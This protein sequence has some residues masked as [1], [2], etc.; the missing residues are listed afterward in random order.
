MNSKDSLE[1]D[2][3]HYEHLY[4]DESSTPK[5]ELIKNIKFFDPVTKMYMRADVI[6]IGKSIGLTLFDDEGHW[7]ILPILWL[8]KYIELKLLDVVGDDF[9]ILIN[10]VEL[11]ISR[12]DYYS[13]W[14]Y[15]TTSNLITN[16]RGLISTNDIEE[17]IVSDSFIFNIVSEFINDIDLEFY[18]DIDNIYQLE[19][20]LE[21]HNGDYSISG[22]DS[23][24]YEEDRIISNKV[25]YIK[26]QDNSYE[27]TLENPSYIEDYIRNRLEKLKD[28]IQGYEYKWDDNEI[29]CDSSF[30][31]LLIFKAIEISRAKEWEEE[32]GEYFNY[33][34]DDKI[35]R[36][37]RAYFNIKDIDYNDQL[38]KIK[39]LCYLMHNN[40]ECRAMGY[41]R[42]YRSLERFLL[43]I[44]EKSKRV[45]NMAEIDL[46]DRFEF[47]DYIIQLF[48]NLKYQVIPLSEVEENEEGIDIVAYIHKTCLYI[49]T[50][51]YPGKIDGNV[52]EDFSVIVNLFEESK[53]YMSFE[54]M[55]SLI[56]TNGTF[57]EDAIEYAQNNDIILWDRSILKD[58]IEELE[59]FY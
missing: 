19:A 59:I 2:Y 15:S 43:E 10:G 22:I 33:M 46:M 28:I 29:I 48:R 36:V 31:H 18:L 16:D 5:S 32:Y 58:R 54:R 53:E 52:I 13:L 17:K 42:A 38:N 9:Y 51:A 24:S 12:D 50:I 47:K 14:G 56:V 55:K 37:I 30:F 27:L 57:T 26:R 45:I 3:E 8:K 4:G 49:K 7:G 34:N 6:I 41:T 25:K 1:N 40:W 20:F 21:E 35:F 23:L 44:E 39:L 11:I